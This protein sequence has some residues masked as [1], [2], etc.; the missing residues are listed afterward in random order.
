MVAAKPRPKCGHSVDMKY[1]AFSLFK[2][3]PGFKAMMLDSLQNVA[4]TPA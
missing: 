2:G 3:P 4:L 1:G